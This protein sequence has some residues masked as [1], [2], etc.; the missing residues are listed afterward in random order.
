MTAGTMPVSPLTSEWACL[1]PLGPLDADLATSIPTFNM[2]DDG[3]R[4]RRESCSARP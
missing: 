2:L 3:L 4:Q 1:L